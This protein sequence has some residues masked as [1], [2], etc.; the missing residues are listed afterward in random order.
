MT[1]THQPIYP[2][3]IKNWVVK[4]LPADTTSFK[5][6][7]TG[8]PDGSRIDSMC[9]TNTATASASDMQFVITISG[10]DYIIDTVQ[11]PVNSGFT[12]GIVS[13]NLLN[14][15]TKF[16]WLPYDGNGNR[17]LYL[18]SGSS[19]RA[20]LGATIATGKEISVF[21]QGGDF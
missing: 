4:F 16:L 11:I 20:K 10:V 12:N 1:V 9:A 15:A 21:A 18:P 19:L 3:S 2:Q 5:T 17:Y 7:A 14:N 8:G 6:I 13:V